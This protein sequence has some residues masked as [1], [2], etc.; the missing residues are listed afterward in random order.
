VAEPLR[1]TGRSS[2]HFTRVAAIFAHELGLAFELEVAHELTATGAASYGGNPA[3]KVPTLHV[4]AAQVFGAENI[5]RRLVE[6]AGRSADPRIVLSEHMRTDLLRN[7]QEL[8]WHAM[9]AQVQLRMGL[10]LCG[11]PADNPFFTKAA[12]GRAGALAWLESRVDQAL[13]QLPA[14][15][16]ISLLEVTLFCLIEHVQFRPT[17][18]LEPYPRLHAFAAAFAQRDSARRT[19]F[20]LDPAPD[21]QDKP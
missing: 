9:A 12:A 21:A 11:L 7:A 16:D 5:C 3:L 1:L 8:V 17:L 14:L 20:R 15:R 2:S 10:T 19:V 13:G 18:P 4:G 6:L